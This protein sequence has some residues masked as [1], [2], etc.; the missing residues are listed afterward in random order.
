MIKGGHWGNCGD[1]A[2]HVGEVGDGLV[3][4]IYGTLQDD[5][6]VGYIT[7]MIASQ[8]SHEEP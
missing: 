4:M 1:G 2:E 7:S 6:W 5:I 3:G 8:N